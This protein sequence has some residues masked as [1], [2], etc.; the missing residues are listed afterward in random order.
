MFCT[1]CGNKIADGIAFCVVCGEPTQWSNNAMQMPEQQQRQTPPPIQTQQQ[2]MHPHTP[3]PEPPKPAKSAKSKKKKKRW[4]KPVIIISVIL[5]VIIGI[6]AVVFVNLGANLT[7]KDTVKHIE[8][9]AKKGDAQ[10]AFYAVMPKA[11]KYVIIDEYFDGDEGDF[12]DAIDEASDL[13]EQELDENG[14]DVKSIE[15]SGK[16]RDAN[17]E[18]EAQIKKEMGEL[19]GLPVLKV[20]SGNL[21]IKYKQYG[22]DYKIKEKAY[23]Y[24][25]PVGWA[26]YVPGWQDIMTQVFDGGYENAN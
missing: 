13:I 5:A 15:L 14:I 25:T 19:Y 3:V 9:A 16:L 17:E 26:V 22:E 10:E 18:M 24:Q 11:G 20:K 7:V 21:K 6:I 12:E 8:T 1:K 23:F 4:V 2:P